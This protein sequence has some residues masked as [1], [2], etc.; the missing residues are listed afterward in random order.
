MAVGLWVDECVAEAVAVLLFLLKRAVHESRDGLVVP[1]AHAPADA[2]APDA[3]RSFLSCEQSALPDY[4]PLSLT[5]RS[6][7]KANSHGSESWDQR[8]GDGV[9]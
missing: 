1:R 4:R 2:G 9:T 7:S 8:P 6:N 3:A 5:P